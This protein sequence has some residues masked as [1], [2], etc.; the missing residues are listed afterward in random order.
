L[1]PPIVVVVN[2]ANMAT[3][4]ALAKIAGKKIIRAKMGQ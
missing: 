3:E 4:A 1:R 2:S